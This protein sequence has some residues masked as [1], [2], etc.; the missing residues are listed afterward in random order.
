MTP[1]DLIDALA[2][3]LQA[4]EEERRR[5]EMPALQVEASDGTLL[6]VTLAAHHREGVLE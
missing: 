1:E 3:M 2:A 6:V 5:D 4:R